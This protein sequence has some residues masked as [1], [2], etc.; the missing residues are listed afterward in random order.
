M[1]LRELWHVHDHTVQD[2]WSQDSNSHIP[3]SKTH[4]LPT[5]CGN[6]F[7][8][9]NQCKFT[10]LCQVAFSLVVQSSL[11]SLPVFQ[12]MSTASS[13][14]STCFKS[15]FSSPFP[16]LSTKTSSN[17]V[18]RGFWRVTYYLVEIL[19]PPVC[20]SIHHFLFLLTTCYTCVRRC[21]EWLLSCKILTVQLSSTVQQEHPCL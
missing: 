18:P 3:D 19:K 10:S 15:I 1:R 9:T 2:W 4:T 8:F 16:R 21:Q 7:L 14:S 6:Q 17:T 12:N 11:N 13:I 20:S 5:L